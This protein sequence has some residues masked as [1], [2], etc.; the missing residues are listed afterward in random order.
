MPEKTKNKQKPAVKALMLEP[1][2]DIFLKETKRICL[3][4]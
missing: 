4:P 2:N 3:G 1:A